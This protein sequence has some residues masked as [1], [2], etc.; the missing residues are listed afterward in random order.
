MSFQ[1]SLRKV[2]EVKENEKINAEQVYS[3]AVQRFEHAATMLYEKLRRKENLIEKS[4]QDLINGL[5]VHY[6]QQREKTVSF[7]EKEI[8]KLQHQTH[9]AR[10]NMADK[11]RFLFSKAIDVKKYQKMKEIEK[12]KYEVNI[13]TAERNF[14]DEIAVQQYVRK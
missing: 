13:K 14:L 6:I 5:S 7:L 10:R 9:E 2:L 4:E 8:E 11:E 3:E 1:Y 12:D